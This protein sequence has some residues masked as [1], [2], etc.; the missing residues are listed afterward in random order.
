MW[1]EL[2][3][4]ELCNVLH[5]TFQSQSS[6]QTSADSYHT[7]NVNNFFAFRRFLSHWLLA[8]HRWCLLLSVAIKVS[9]NTTKEKHRTSSAYSCKFNSN[10]PAQVGLIM[11]AQNWRTQ[12]SAAYCKHCKFSFSS[13]P[14]IH[15]FAHLNVFVQFSSFIFIELYSKYIIGR[16]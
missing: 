6:T 16:V 1:S 8:A 14:Y 13:V 9:A 10:V 5:P 3:L 4:A 2:V 11:Q 12:T 7:Q 15:Q